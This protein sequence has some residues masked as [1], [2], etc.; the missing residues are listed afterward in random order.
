MKISWGRVEGG[1]VLC[2][3]HRFGLAT[4][5]WKG[6]AT[7]RTMP[8]YMLACPGRLVVT[9]VHHGAGCPSCPKC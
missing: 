9:E 1:G 4:G 7:V 3:H 2:G 8:A 6:S 5:R